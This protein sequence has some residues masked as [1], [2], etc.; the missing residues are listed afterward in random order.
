MNPALKIPDLVSLR[1]YGWK[2]KHF[3]ISIS[4]KMKTGLS[5]FDIFSLPSLTC[6][7]DVCLQSFGCFPHHR[8][9]PAGM[10]L[11][12]PVLNLVYYE[13]ISRIEF[14][15]YTFKTVFK[16]YSSIQEYPR[17]L[18]LSVRPKSCV[19]PF[20]TNG[21]MALLSSYLWM[22]AAAFLLALLLTHRDSQRPSRPSQLQKRMILF[23]WRS[24]RK[25]N[26]TV[27][28]FAVGKGF[29]G[30]V[31]TDIWTWTWKMILVCWLDQ[32]AHIWYNV[33]NIHVHYMQVIYR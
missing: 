2:I 8:N 21:V 18:I 33:W 20:L 6:P 10:S 15:E 26:F 22:C 13:M 4:L 23:A 12:V 27:P 14:Q 25:G 7:Q 17:F 16:I 1:P 5:F 28:G 31:R 11:K 19:L 9:Y 30:S 24:W 3:R 29:S 32:L